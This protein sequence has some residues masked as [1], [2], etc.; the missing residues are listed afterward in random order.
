MAM[1]SQEEENYVRINCLLTGISPNAVRTYFDKEFHP[2]CLYAS[3]KQE[4]TK[5][6]DLK[7]QRVINVAQWNL[8]YPRGGNTPSSKQFDVT[9]MITLIR[10]LTKIGHPGRGYEVLPQP[11][12]TTTGD[13]LARIKYYRNHIAHLDNATLDSSFFNQAWEDISNAVGR[14]GGKVLLDECKS[15]RTKTLDHS[16]HEIIKEINQARKEMQET[17]RDV[18]TLKM[19]FDSLKINY[20]DLNHDHNELIEDYGTLRNDHERTNNTV[21]E[22]RQ[23]YAD[24]LPRGLRAKT[25][26]TLENWVEDAK[27]HVETQ[28]D[29]HIFECITRH[30]C[31]LV[32]GSFGIGKTSTMKNVALR[33]NE[34][35]YDVI[36]VID[37]PRDILNFYN[38]NQGT[39]FVI[40]DFCGKYTLKS[41]QF[42]RWKNLTDDILSIIEGGNC[43][44]IVSCRLQVYNDS[45]FTTLSL[46]KNCICNLMSDNLSLT[47]TEKSEITFLFLRSDS[48]KICKLQNIFNCFPLLCKQFHDNPTS[49]ITQVFTN[50][51]PIL[52]TEINQL[53]KGRIYGKYCALALCVKFENSLHE[54]VLTGDIDK[55][56]RSLFKNICEK[57]NLDRGTSRL[58]L[59]DELDSLIDTFLI[60]DHGCYRFKH[61]QY[62]EF[63]RCYFSQI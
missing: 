37:D 63:F 61:E 25:K 44:I 48:S 5:L 29:K 39:L 56:T 16:N 30:Q 22:L 43:K 36:P 51:S 52:E 47:H 6:N 27:M 41:S 60:N 26:R 1:F 59:K 19:S 50:H 12:D 10:H 31:V 38:P 55:K 13:D 53:Q 28:K 62:F 8:L 40:D 57:C 18:V 21:V 33:M 54:N 34:S 24:T 46:F 2:S 58:L 42:E 14:L 7:K 3:I 23:T 4:Y 9:L 32:T 49:D 17:K 35:G 15:L 20:T 45:K 11:T